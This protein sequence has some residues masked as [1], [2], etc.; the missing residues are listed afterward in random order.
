M[1]NTISGWLCSIDIN[2]GLVTDRVFT[3]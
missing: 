2:S 1:A 3:K